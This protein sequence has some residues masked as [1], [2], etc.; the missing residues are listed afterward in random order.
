MGDH[1]S[2]KQE[3]PLGIN[4]SPGIILKPLNPDQKVEEGTNFSLT[5]KDGHDYIFSVEGQDSLN[6]SN[7]KN[8][9][10]DLGLNSKPESPVKSAGSIGEKQNPTQ[11]SDYS[12]NATQQDNASSSRVDCVVSGSN[13][14]VEDNT[15]N[16]SKNICFN[17]NQSSSPINRSNS[18]QVYNTEGK[19]RVLLIKSTNNQ[20]IFSNPNHTLKYLDDSGLNEFKCGPHEVQGRGGCLKLLVKVNEHFDANKI[21]KLGDNSVKAWFPALENYSYGVIFPVDRNIALNDIHSNI[22][23]VKSTGTPIVELKRLQNKEGTSNLLKITFDGPLPNKVALYGQT[24]FVRKFN[25]DPLICYRCSKWGHGVISCSGSIHC[26]LCGGSHYLKECDKSNA[27]PKCFHC[28]DEHITGSKLCEFYNKAAI[29]ESL[30]SDKKITYAES[31]KYYN[32][33]NRCCLKD[34]ENF[35]TSNRL[36]NLGSNSNTATNYKYGPDP[37]QVKN[38]INNDCSTSSSWVPAEEHLFEISNPFSL[39]HDNINTSRNYE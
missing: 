18:T 10:T 26:G 36:N 1:S 22:K 7:S 23:L 5:G 35:L 19:P 2:E 38:R 9:E 27:T 31:K 32:E 20:N 37:S 39:L 24:Y 3:S 11:N 21:T 16:N 6:K 8:D 17:S 12:K 14:N 29:I 25:K 30:K 13:G 33:L 15:S 34:L 28:K 4:L